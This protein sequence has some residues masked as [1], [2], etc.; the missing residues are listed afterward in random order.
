[1]RSMRSGCRFLRN[2]KRPESSSKGP[3]DQTRCCIILNSR[4]LSVYAIFTQSGYAD[5]VAEVAD[6]ARIV[7]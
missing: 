2:S 1:M 4:M 6:P 7:A 5:H 3:K